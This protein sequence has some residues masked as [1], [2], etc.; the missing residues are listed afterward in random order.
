MVSHSEF[1]AEVTEDKK[2]PES[3]KEPLGVG[4]WPV[5]AHRDKDEETEIF[6]PLTRGARAN[7]MLLVF[8]AAFV[9]VTIVG[10]SIGVFFGLVG[11]L[12]VGEETI[13]QWTT[14][15]TRDDL[16]ILFQANFLDR[17]III[18]VELLYTSGLIA[19][20]SALQFALLSMTNDNYK[21]QFFADIENE[22]R[23]P[24]AVRELYIRYLDR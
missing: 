17:S 16:N 24:L 6:T 11:M 1:W 19:T 18:T 5:R 9:R 3:F 8:F 20:L 21:K 7:L 10:M 14:N 12:A 22:V 2:E 4:G 13:L 23:R 15:M